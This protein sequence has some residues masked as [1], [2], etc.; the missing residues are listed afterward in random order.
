MGKLMLPLFVAS[1]ILV[2]SLAVAEEDLIGSAEYLNSCATCHG[3]EGKGD[4]TLAKHLDIHPANLTV[5][6]KNNDGVYPFLKVFQN[7]DGRSATLGH[8]SMLMPVW[9]DRYSMDIGE[10]Y[11]AFGSETAVR[12][13]ILELVYYIQTIQQ[14]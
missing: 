4:G 12:A 1:S 13:R 11:G 6:A 7:I 3:V 14:K 2:S 10:K 9:G 5:L 8:G